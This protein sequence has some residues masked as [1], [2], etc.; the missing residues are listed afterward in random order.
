MISI[1]RNTAS[2]SK[3]HPFHLKISQYQ[4][5]LRGLDGGGGGPGTAVN[6]EGAG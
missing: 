5:N 3:D 2:T 6:L 4:V 1:Q